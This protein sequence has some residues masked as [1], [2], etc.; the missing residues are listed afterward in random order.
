MSKVQDYL[1]AAAIGA[2]MLYLG[3]AYERHQ[4]ALACLQGDAVAVGKQTGKNAK[5]EIAGTQTVAQE[6]IDYVHLTTAPLAPVATAR[7]PA[8]VQPAAVPRDAGAAVSA[9]CSGQGVDAA[10]LLRAQ[11][12]AESLRDNLDAANRSAVQIGRDADAQVSGLQD[13]ATRVCRPPKR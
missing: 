12:E 13:Y 11:G 5:A 2:L 7:R 9:A 1:I 3:I 6:G 10:V 4:G 8:R